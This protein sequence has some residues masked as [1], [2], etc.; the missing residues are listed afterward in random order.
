MKRA[1]VQ[2]LQQHALLGGEW[3]GGVEDGI[4]TT[5]LNVD[6]GPSFGLAV[7]TGHV[8][9]S[10]LPSRLHDPLLF[11]RL[12]KEPSDRY[13]ACLVVLFFWDL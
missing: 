2:Q 4:R 5:K 1:R 10:F 3:G 11:Q 9:G 7:A 13:L 12:R 6:A 8:K